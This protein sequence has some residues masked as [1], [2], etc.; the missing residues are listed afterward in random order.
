MHS[1]KEI[2][3]PRILYSTM[4]IFDS[5]ARNDEVAR[6]LLTARISNIISEW[7]VIAECLF[8]IELWKSTPEIAMLV[9]EEEADLN[10]GCVSSHR[11]EDEDSIAEVKRWES[12]M[13]TM[14]FSL[15]L[16]GSLL[17]RTSLFLLKLS[18]SSILFEEDYVT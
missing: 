7:S 15:S 13:K 8:Q 9:H 17:S 12:F 16:S 3:S 2:K 4:D 18:I 6:K 5:L 10:C 14:T 1:H 11:E